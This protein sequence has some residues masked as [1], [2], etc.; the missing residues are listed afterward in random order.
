M[1]KNEYIATAKAIRTRGWQPLVNLLYLR[2]LTALAT[3]ISGSKSWHGCGKSLG[4]LQA[5]S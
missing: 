2:I 3:A 5:E 4:N 1:P